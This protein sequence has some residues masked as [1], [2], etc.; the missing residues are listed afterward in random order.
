MVVVVAG[1]KARRKTGEYSFAGVAGMELEKEELMIERRG[2]RR[3]FI[4]IWDRMT[5]L[6]WDQDG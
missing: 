2:W 6:G 3:A 1:A 4:E 5:R